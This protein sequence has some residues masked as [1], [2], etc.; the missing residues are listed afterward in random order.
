MRKMFIDFT[1][2][3]DILEPMSKTATKQATI[4]SYGRVDE[5]RKKVPDSWKKAAGSMKHHARALDRYIKRVR[6]EWR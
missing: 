5:L 1:Q 3:A 2:I 6:K 4:I